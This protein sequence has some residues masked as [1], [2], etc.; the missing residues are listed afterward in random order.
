MGQ[1][2]AICSEPNMAAAARKMSL[3]PPAISQII[4]HIERELGVTVFERSSRG[5]RLTPAG[6]VLRRRARELVE[7]EAE[8][9]EA[10]VPYR[11]QLLPKLRVQ[12]AST[13]ANHIAPAIVAE[14]NQVVGEIQFKSGGADHAVHDFLKGEF[15]ILISSEDLSGI[16]NLERFRLCQERFIGLVPATIPKEQCNL[17]WLAANL[18][19]IRSESTSLLDTMIETYLLKHG[20]KPPRAIESRTV[21]PMVEII[22][23]GLGWAITTPFNIGYY[24]A[25]NSKAAFMELPPPQS[26]REINLFANSGQLL[27]FPRKLAGVCRAALQNE[28]RSWKG[29]SNAALSVAVN[30]D[31][32]EVSADSLQA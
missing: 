3:S 30:V 7:A 28:V 19:M 20:L 13:V 10:L 22:G 31:A 2:L 6:N 29:G 32:P 12:I 8:M 4:R 11:N 5:I 26:W 16:S 24:Y 1:F 9:L 14:L 25:L 17:P 15:D 27:D 23:Q 21:A 18:P